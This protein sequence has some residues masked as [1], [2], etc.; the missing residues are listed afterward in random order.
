MGMVDQ[1]MIAPDAQQVFSQPRPS[2]PNTHVLSPD[3]VSFQR[4]A[5]DGDGKEDVQSKRNP[6]QT[7]AVIAPVDIADSEIFDMWHSIKDCEPAS[8][9]QENT[10]HSAEHGKNTSMPLPSASGLVQAMQQMKA[11][12]EQQKSELDE[13]TRGIRQRSVAARSA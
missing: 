7:A 4:Q 1:K 8:N 11:A 9:T 5:G 3:D 13:M 6:P 10:H 12:L 2:Q